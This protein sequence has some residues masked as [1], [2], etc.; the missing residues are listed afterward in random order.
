MPLNQKASPSSSENSGEIP[1]AA[2][3]KGAEPRREINA[4]GLRN[5]TFSLLSRLLHPKLLI[6]ID[7]L[8]ESSQGCLVP[9]QFPKQEEL[10]E[11][12]KGQ[13]TTGVSVPH[14]WC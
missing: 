4:C 7:L 1:E 9:V 12:K 13:G 5:L 6:H 2:T 14:H 11:L 8:S 10:S 3:V